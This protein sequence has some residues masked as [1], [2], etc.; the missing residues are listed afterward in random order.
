LALFGTGHDND[1]VAE[2]GLFANLAI[3]AGAA[4]IVWMAGVRITH[5]AN[6]ISVR[7]GI[8]QACRCCW[9]E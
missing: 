5:Y 1:G 4:A 6:V 2:L 8:G 9:A 7:T 3:F